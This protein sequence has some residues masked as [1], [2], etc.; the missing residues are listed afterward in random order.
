MLAAPE[1]WSMHPSTRRWLVG[2][3]VAAIVVPVLVVELWMRPP[4]PESL[5]ENARTLLVQRKPEAA[6]K[7]IRKALAGLGEDGNRKLRQKAM[8]LR[9]EIADHHLSDAHIP[10]A[11]GAYREVAE[12]FPDTEVAWSAGRRTADILRQRLRDNVHAQEQYRRVAV[13]FP[14]HA[15]VDELW[16]T[17]AQCAMDDRRFAAARDDAKR[18]VDDYPA[19][20]HA[21]EAQNL[22]ARSFKLEGKLPEATKAFLAVADRWPGTEAGARALHEAGD[23]LAEQHDNA[24]AVA[25][26]LGA[27]ANHPDPGLVQKS[28]ERARRKLAEE[29]PPPVGSKA[30]AFAR[31][32]R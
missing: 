7:E 32:K 4:S 2:G 29:A 24:G 5:L 13:T 28:L 17:A 3:V 19:S 23:C 8:L 9:A 6:L 16:L 12:A 30:Y 27:L 10:E 1:A 11:I 22:L 26:Y 31:A 20:D 15:G 21:A 25:R 18:L 14:D